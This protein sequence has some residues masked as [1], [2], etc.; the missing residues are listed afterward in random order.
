MKKIDS[1]TIHYD[2]CFVDGNVVIFDDLH[3][4]YTP[5]SKV[6]RYSFTDLDKLHTCPK[7]YYSQSKYEIYPKDN[8]IHGIIG[9]YLQGVYL[10]HC[11]GTDTCISAF[12][13][14]AIK[15]S[16]EVV[17]Y[18]KELDRAKLT[19]TYKIMTRGYIR[20]MY[21]TEGFDV[22]KYLDKV[23]NVVNNIVEL[24]WTIAPG[25]FKNLYV[26]TGIY[27]TLETGEIIFGKADLIVEHYSGDYTIIDHKSSFNTMYLKRLQLPVYALLLKQPIR[28]L[29][30]NDMSS[31]NAYHYPKPTLDLTK[32]ASVF[33]QEA[34]S[35]RVSIDMEPEAIIGKQCHGCQVYDCIETMT[36]E[37]GY[38]NV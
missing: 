20:K 13:S 7:S 6:E 4:D 27:T 14:E 19:D 18:H 37:E 32:E 22:E 12:E 2:K 30:I 1:N 38:L 23:R 10:N 29:I 5:A 8:S 28:N 11:Y 25:T 31:G 21:V 33:I 24:H 3:E 17:T 15:L 26:E 35:K 34:L 16:K 9:H 36:D